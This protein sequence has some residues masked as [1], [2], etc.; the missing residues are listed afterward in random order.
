MLSGKRTARLRGKVMAFLENEAGAVDI[1]TR[2]LDLGGNRI[3]QR[4]KKHAY[5]GTQGNDNSA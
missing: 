4:E 1:C 5:G 3:G 2:L